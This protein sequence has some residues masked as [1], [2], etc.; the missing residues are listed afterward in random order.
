MFVLLKD[1]NNV[2][3]QIPRPKRDCLEWYKL[4]DGETRPAKI[5]ISRNN[6]LEDIKKSKPDVSKMLKES[7]LMHDN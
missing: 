6:T 7:A 1:C 2:P 5:N 3:P 4:I